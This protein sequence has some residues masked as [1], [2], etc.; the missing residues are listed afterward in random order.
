[1]GNPSRNFVIRCEFCE[2]ICHPVYQVGLGS[3]TSTLHQCENCFSARVDPP[4][5]AESVAAFYA[6]SY[7]DAAEWQRKKSAVLAV[8]YFEKVSPYL[9]GGRSLEVGAG[10]GDFAR[11]FKTRT[12]NGM[13]VVEPSEACR[14]MMSEQTQTGEVF[15]SLAELPAGAAYEQIFCFHVVE[16]LQAFA[17]F[18]AELQA[19]LVQG[20]RL[21]ILTPNGASDSFREFGRDWGWACTEQH[22]QFLSDQIPAAYFTQHGFR[23]V[24]QKSVCPAVIHY[25]GRWHTRIERGLR[26]L[27]TRA[28]N[29]DGAQRWMLKG[30]QRLLLAAE[31]AFAQNRSNCNATFLE[32]QLSLRK[33]NAHQDE[34]LLVL[35]K[36]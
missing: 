30:L 33:R 36:N 4:F 22:H 17:P 35:E 28:K 21:F 19:K 15:R 14:K 23:V 6:D 32:K 9:R 26:E 13:D 7:F 29:A 12:G 5:P 24:A 34:L 20:G 11:C 25:P 10:Y 3:L 27:D 31:P 16:H 8:D 1:M 2:G 18:A